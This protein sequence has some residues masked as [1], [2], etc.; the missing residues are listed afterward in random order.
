METPVLSHPELPQEVPLVA[1][2]HD[3]RNR[4][5]YYYPIIDQID[6]VNT[7]QTKFFE[8]EGDIKSHPHFDYR[9]VTSF[10]Q[11][12]GAQRVFLRGDY[13]SAKLNGTDG[14]LIDSQDPYDIQ[15][16]FA[17]YI[18]QMIMLGRHIGKRIAIREWIEHDAEVRFFIEDGHITYGDTLDD[19][20]ETEWPWIQARHVA[21]EMDTYSWSVD[22]IRDAHAAVW[23]CIDMGLNGLYHDGTEWISISEHL[24]EEQSPERYS[25]KMPQPK[26]FVWVK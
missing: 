13:S 17:E 12:I 16:V 2:F 21:R 1:D 11:D 3:D 5:S 20:E 9:E 22:F 15:S 23:Y 26:R 24:D 7:P 14:S 10:I 18:R 4:L 25:D 6:E 19:V 8:I